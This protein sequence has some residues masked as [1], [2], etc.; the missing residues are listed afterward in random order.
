MDSYEELKQNLETLL[1]EKREFFSS[2]KSKKELGEII[3]IANR[4]PSYEKKAE[5]FLSLIRN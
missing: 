5:K 2:M 3:E 4:E 1:S